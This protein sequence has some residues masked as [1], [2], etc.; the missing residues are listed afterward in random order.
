MVWDMKIHEKIAEYLRNDA[1]DQRIALECQQFRA[2][3]FSLPKFSN[4]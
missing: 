4:H 3:I 1:Y 2:G